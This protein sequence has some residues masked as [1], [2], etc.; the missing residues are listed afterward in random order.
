MMNCGLTF[1]PSASALCLTS[2]RADP[3][4]QLESQKRQNELTLRRAAFTA[5]YLN[6]MPDTLRTYRPVGKA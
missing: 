3:S 2:T 6:E 1:A 5:A 4:L